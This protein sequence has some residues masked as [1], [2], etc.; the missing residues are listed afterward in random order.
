MSPFRKIHINQDA[1]L[2]QI[3]RLRCVCEATSAGREALR[4]ARLAGDK[5]QQVRHVVGATGGGGLVFG[6]KNVLFGIVTTIIL[7]YIHYPFSIIHDIYLPYAI[8]HIYHISIYHIYHD[9]V[10]TIHDHE[11][12]IQ[13]SSKLRLCECENGH[14]VDFPSYKM[15]S[16]HSE[17]LVYQK[18]IA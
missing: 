3:P 14:R 16:F 6:H 18:V 15:M 5:V 1:R 9:I 17:R 8:Y 12:I 13:L 2:P 10:S 7:S 11:D 4:L